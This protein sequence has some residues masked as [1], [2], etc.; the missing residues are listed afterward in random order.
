MRIYENYLVE[1]MM[2]MI[3]LLHHGSTDADRFKIIAPYVVHQN[4]ISYF[5][6]VKVWISELLFKKMQLKEQQ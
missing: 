6:I 5:S 4:C 1:S 2:L 3:T